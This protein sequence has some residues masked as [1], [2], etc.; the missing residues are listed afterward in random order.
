SIPCLFP[1]GAERVHP[2]SAVLKT[3]KLP[4]AWFLEPGGHLANRFLTGRAGHGQSPPPRYLYAYRIY[5]A[6][7]P[8]PTQAFRLVRSAHR[9]GRGS[10]TNNVLRPTH[11]D[12][13]DVW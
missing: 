11:R 7:E 5:S 10:G 1:P 6:R 4:L 9:T 8:L 12:A 13:A 3:R 2:N